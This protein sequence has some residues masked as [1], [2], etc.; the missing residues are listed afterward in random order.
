ME[1]PSAQSVEES[2]WETRR[3]LKERVGSTSR[4]RTRH[5]ST[6]INNPL[7]VSLVALSDVTDH[8][9]RLIELKQKLDANGL[10]RDNPSS[11]KT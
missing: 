3:Y 8:E 6:L 2:S 11:F 10:D 1:C 9:D 4:Y 5:L 7:S